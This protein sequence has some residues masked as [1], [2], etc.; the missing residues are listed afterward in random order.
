VV[1]VD[2]VDRMGEPVTT[3]SP[4]TSEFTNM[5]YESTAPLTSEF[6]SN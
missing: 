5:D 1:A 6:A 4:T 3:T 2:T